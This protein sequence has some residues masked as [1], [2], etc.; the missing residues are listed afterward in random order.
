MKPI[1]EDIEN[2]KDIDKIVRHF[3][4]MLMTDPL[5]KHFFIEV[6]HIDLD[7]HIPV[8]V[9]FWENILFHTG[10]YKANAMEKHFKLHDDSPIKQ[11]HF[12]QWLTLF[13]EAVDKDFSGE[14]ADKAK[15]RAQ[16]VAGLMAH[17]MKHR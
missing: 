9:D 8:I 6:R 13:I 10:A 5:V 1:K 15:L 3:Y 2:R 17:Q 12:D 7:E 16:Q 4:S 11:S 14:I